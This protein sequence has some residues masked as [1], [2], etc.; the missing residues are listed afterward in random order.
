MM[1]TEEAERFLSS[2]LSN[3]KFFKQSRGSVRYL[4]NVP[5]SL[6]QLKSFNAFK[7]KGR[8]ELMPKE[9]N[10]NEYCDEEGE[11]EEQ[12]YEYDD[13]EEQLQDEEDHEEIVETP[14]AKNKKSKYKQDNSDEEDSFS[15]GR[16]T[17]PGGIS[18]VNHNKFYKK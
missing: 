11:E 15:H 18:I 17:Q 1:G 9:N 7:E 14:K 3:A 5:D 8:W 6:K 13:Y 12:Y 10:Q 2:R 16:Y 4:S